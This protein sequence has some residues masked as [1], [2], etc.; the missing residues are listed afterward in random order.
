MT[1]ASAAALNY[2]LDKSE[3]ERV[4]PLCSLALGKTLASSGYYPSGWEGS[5]GPIVLDQFMRFGY[6]TLS[7][8]TKN[9]CA[10]KYEYPLNNE[11]D[12]GN[13]MS[14]SNYKQYSKS[15]MWETR[16]INTGHR[17]YW[18][19]ILTME[20]RFEI[21]NSGEQYD[22][23]KVLTDV[24][25]A[26]LNNNSDTKSIVTIGT[27][28]YG[29]LCHAG[30]CA[31][32]NAQ[33]DTWA[34]SGNIKHMLRMGVGPDA[35]HEIAIVGYD[36]NATAVDREGFTHKGLLTIRNS[37]GEKTGDKGNFYMTYDYFKMFVDEV[38]KVSKIVIT[39]ND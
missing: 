38:Q 15:L 21:E 28:L 25:K 17:V 3:S 26:L 14:L 31:K 7:N 22:G 19:P 20:Q 2:V 29:D 34:M 33:D 1:F 16:S 18:S 12:E 9:G 35:G 32:R 13:P 4:S 30:A 11:R 24:K 10:G 27:M 8:Q 23:E 5:F 6:I 37:W 36:D 39:V